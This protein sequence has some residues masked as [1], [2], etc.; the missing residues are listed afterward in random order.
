[1]VAK[2]FPLHMAIG[3]GTA[4]V[5]EPRD[6]NAFAYRQLF[7]TKANCIDPADN[8]VAGNDRYQRIRKFTIYDV[9]ICPADAARRY[10]D[11]N[12][13]RPGLS[14]KQFGPIEW[15]SEFIQ[16]HRMH[17]LFLHIPWS[18]ATGAKWGII[19]TPHAAD[20][21]IRPSTPVPNTVATA[22][23]SGGLSS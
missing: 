19:T 6:T 4:G 23:K 3:T 22:K 15:R 20:L 14:I 8:F 2:V 9:Q 10:F 21:V 11:P 16:Y 1:M 7:D 17:S 5:A 18:L 13:P 12:L